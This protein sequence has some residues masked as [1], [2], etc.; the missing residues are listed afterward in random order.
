MMSIYIK[1][2][3]YFLN[4]FDFFSQ[5]KIINYFNFQFKKKEIVFF[6]VGAHFG[7]TVYL[8]SKYLKVKQ[9]HCFEASPRNFEILKKKIENSNYSNICHLNNFG[10]GH[11]SYDTFI[12]QTK[13]SSSSTINNINFNSSYFKKKIKILNISKI[14][15]YV[16]KIPI[17][18]TFLDHY[19]N[20]NKIQLIDILKI[21]TEGFEFEVLKGLT[22]NFKKVKFIYFEHHYDDMIKK[23][24]IFSDIH[25]LLEKNNFKKTMKSKMIF[26]KSFEY[27]YE[28]MLLNS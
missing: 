4:F 27:I 1:F 14:D 22:K 23:N 3:R 12:N 21:D 28:N 25:N 20:Q 17:K 7:E 19:I 6:D 16:E 11:K 13:E 15:S 24:Y 26:R 5:K 10:L 8:F 9:F 18:V 2:I